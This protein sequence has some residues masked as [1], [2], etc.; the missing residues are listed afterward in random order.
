MKG[1]SGKM[2]FMSLIAIAILAIGGYMAY[3]FIGSNLEQK[4]I[5]KEVFDTLGITRG[6]D[7]DD[8]GRMAVI[9]EVLLK[10]GVE[11]LDIAARLEGGIIHYSFSYRMVTNFLLFKRDE[12]IEVADQIQNYM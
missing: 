7:L 3:K 12:V 10:H 2:T 9:E 6:G 1:Q 8:A 11:I 4:Q 5:K